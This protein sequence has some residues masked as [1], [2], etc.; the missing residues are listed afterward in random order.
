MQALV[1]RGFDGF[2]AIPVEVG[3]E[4]GHPD[5]RR[6]VRI[7]DG[8]VIRVPWYLGEAQVIGRSVPVQVI[9]LSDE[10]IVGLGVLNN[11]RVT[12]DHGAQ[13]IVD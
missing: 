7:A 10:Y 8:Q 5:G 3:N 11:F 4:L 1:D 13:V 9:A 2:L 12:L 6:R